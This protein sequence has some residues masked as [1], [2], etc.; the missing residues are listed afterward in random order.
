MGLC[1]MRLRVI[2]NVHGVWE[3]IEPGTNLDAKENSVAMALFYQGIPKEQIMQI[4]NL[5]TAKETCGVFK[6]RHLGV[7]RIREVQTLMGKFENLKMKDQEVVDLKTIGYDDVVGRLKAYEERIKVEEIQTE[8]NQLLFASSDEKAKRKEYRC[9][10]CGFVNSRREDFGRGRGGGRGSE[11]DRGDSRVQR[12]K[13][14]VKCYK[15]NEFGHYISECS[16]WEK[17][18][19]LNLNRIEEEEPALFLRNYRTGFLKQKFKNIMKPAFH[20]LVKI[21]QSMVNLEVNFGGEF[22]PDVKT[23]SGGL[24]KQYCMAVC[25][26]VLTNVLAFLKHDIPVVHKRVWLFKDSNLPTKVLEDDENWNAM[27][28]RAMTHNEKLW[29]ISNS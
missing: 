14:H 10:D 19:E 7:D 15:C 9:E 6:T 20:L 18:D 22:K 16:K 4:G 17:N 5:M 1:A 27:F 21:S 8:K 26:L 24:K 29:C 12:D 3:M 2:F 28:D 23:Y 11:R 13:S 25:N